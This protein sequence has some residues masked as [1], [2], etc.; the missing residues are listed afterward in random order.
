MLFN[1]INMEG[2]FMS[3][4]GSFANQ[5]KWSGA[6]K[7]EEYTE[8]IESFGDMIRVWAI[9]PA[10]ENIEEFMAYAKD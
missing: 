2:P 6:I 7:K 1:K 5:F 10:R 8:L 9:D 4:T 3:L